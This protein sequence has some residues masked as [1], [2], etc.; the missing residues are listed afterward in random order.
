MLAAH[1]STTPITIS[2]STQCVLMALDKCHCLHTALS[3]KKGNLLLPPT[4]RP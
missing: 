1:S 3:T 4:G 2:C